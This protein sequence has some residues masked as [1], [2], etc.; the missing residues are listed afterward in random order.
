MRSWLP[1]LRNNWYSV[2]LAVAGAWVLWRVVHGRSIVGAGHISPED[3]IA[4][5]WTVWQAGMTGWLEDSPDGTQHVMHDTG[6]TG[7]PY[8]KR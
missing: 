8:T 2:L 6:W 3:A 4:D 1:W 7:D 5:G